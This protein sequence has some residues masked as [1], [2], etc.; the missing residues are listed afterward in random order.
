MCVC[1]H[2]HP[3]SHV[4]L[5]DPIDCSPSGFSVHGIFQARILEWVLIFYSRG[6]SLTQEQNL[7]Y[8]ER[9]KVKSLSRVRL[10]ATPRTVAYQVPLSM[11]FSRQEYWSGL[12]SPSPSFH[13]APGILIISKKQPERVSAVYKK[14]VPQRTQA[15]QEGVPLVSLS[16]LCQDD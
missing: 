8:L 13:E 2:T 10:F 11:E 9:K 16:S 15:K 5:C 7:Q 12:S 1:A 14:P 4:R 6:I 3:L